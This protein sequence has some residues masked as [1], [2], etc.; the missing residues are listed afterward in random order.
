MACGVYGI[1]PDS[2]KIPF[3][4]T[5]LNDRR[6]YGGGISFSVWRINDEKTPARVFAVKQ[7]W[8]YMVDPI[9]R[10]KKV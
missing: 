8:V 3:T 4:A 10:I 5:K 1:V 7:L 2:L 6:P 9:D